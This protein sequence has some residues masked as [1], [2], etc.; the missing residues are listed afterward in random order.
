MER[1][2]G[3]KFKEVHV[4]EL[5]FSYF[6]PSRLKNPCLAK[7]EPWKVAVDENFLLVYQP[8]FKPG[9]ICKIVLDID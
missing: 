4:K 7:G 2:A 3:D 1:M 5:P 6:F 9:R 8:D